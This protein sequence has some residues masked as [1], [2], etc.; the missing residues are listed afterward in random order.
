MM[1]FM[2]STLF[3]VN[4]VDKWVHYKSM[5]G[6]KREMCVEVVVSLHSQQ[7]HS[8]VLNILHPAIYLKSKRFISRC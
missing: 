6:E 5:E 2:S 7:H 1:T 4:D 8:T 3:Y